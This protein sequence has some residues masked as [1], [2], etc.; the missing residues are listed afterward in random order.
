MPTP[1]RQSPVGRTVR[2]GVPPGVAAVGGPVH[3]F[4]ITGK[5][6]LPQRVTFR[7][8]VEAN[9]TAL[10]PVYLQPRMNQ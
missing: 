6:S 1:P 3:R 9:K 4:S 7:V 5:A 2:V 10:S 8:F